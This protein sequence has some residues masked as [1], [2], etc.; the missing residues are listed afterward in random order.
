MLEGLDNVDWKSLTHAYGSAEDVPDQLR[1][2][3][4]D[5]PKVRDD[6]WGALESNIY[7]QGSVHQATAYAVPVLPHTVAPAAPPHTVR[8]MPTGHE[9]PLAHSV[10]FHHSTIFST[11]PLFHK[12][13]K[14]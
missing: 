11:S 6:A 8:H 1:N 12:P 14:S 10:N 13:H 7:H 3:I 5:D 9:R 2:L 4:S